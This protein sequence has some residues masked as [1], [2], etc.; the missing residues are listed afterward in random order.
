VDDAADAFLRAGES[1]ACNGEVFNVVDDDLPSSRKLLR[2]YKRNVKRFKSLYVPKSVSYLLC[3]MWERY[4]GWS[5]GQVPLAFNRKSWHTFWKTTSYSNQK[6]KTRVG[7]SQIVPTK[8]ALRR[9]FEACR[10][11]GVNA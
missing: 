8:E 2:L 3:Y 1:G 4:S 7:W 9:Y 11:G 5:E 6:L 10:M